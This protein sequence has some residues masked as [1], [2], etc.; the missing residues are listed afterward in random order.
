[1]GDAEHAE[2]VVESLESAAKAHD[3]AAASPDRKPLLSRPEAHAAGDQPAA[4]HNPAD[5]A[6]VVVKAASSDDTIP[7]ELASA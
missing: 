1:M 2:A 6:R 4:A 7:V 3:T 5:A